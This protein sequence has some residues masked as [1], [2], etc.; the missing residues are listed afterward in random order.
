MTPVRWSPEA[1]KGVAT[2]GL[3]YLGPVLCWKNLHQLSESCL[4]PFQES[5]KPVVTCG[6]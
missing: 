1:A 2:R 5:W 6:H 3:S 4:L